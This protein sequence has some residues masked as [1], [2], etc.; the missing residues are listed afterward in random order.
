[1]WC[2]ARLARNLL[3]RYPD[4][5]V[6]GLEVDG[7]QYAKNLAAP[8]Q[9]LEFVAAGAESLPFAVCR[10]PI[11]DC[12]LPIADCSFDLAM[13]KSLHHVPVHSMPQARSEAARVL[14][15]GGHLYVSEPVFAGPFNEVVLLCSDEGVVR[16]A[17]QAALDVALAGGALGTRRPIKPSIRRCDLPT[18]ATLNKD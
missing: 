13:L 12:R 2:A 9:G 18:L 8:Q 16:A 5:Q 6:T 14:R 17:A 3:F 11:A 15:P 4:R 7:R 10:L 1:M